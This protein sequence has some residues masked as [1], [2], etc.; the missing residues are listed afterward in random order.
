[1]ELRNL[2]LM[3]GVVKMISFDSIFETVTEKFAIRCK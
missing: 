3:F 1:M 2:F